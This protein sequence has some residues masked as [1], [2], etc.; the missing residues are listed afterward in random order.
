MI[1]NSANTIGLAGSRFAH[2][3]QNEDA[4]DWSELP[5]SGR[6]YPLRSWPDTDKIPKGSGFLGAHLVQSLLDDGHEVV[7][8]DNF[9]T[10]QA[11]NLDHLSTHPNFE[12]IKYGMNSG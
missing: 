12:L 8:L 11:S 10:G 3:E 9:W 7:V 4:G 5:T 6:R 1:Q 2:H